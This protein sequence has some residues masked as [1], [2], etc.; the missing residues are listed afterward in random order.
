MYTEPFCKDSPYI[1]LHYMN[2]W[3]WASVNCLLQLP[4]YEE[5]IAQASHSQDTSFTRA[6]ERSP[7]SI[8]C[9]AQSFFEVPK[10]N[11]V[12]THARLKLVN[13]IKWQIHKFPQVIMWYKRQQSGLLIP[14][15]LGLMHKVLDLHLP[16]QECDDTM[17]FSHKRNVLF[18][19]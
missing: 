11:G 4:I 16:V 15:E 13:A 10:R 2:T 9:H 6:R 7:I 17:K 1:K 14:K 3:K 18:S 8:V 19:V 12:I 5:L